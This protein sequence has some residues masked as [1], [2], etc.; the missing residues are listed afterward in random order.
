MT[1]QSD[2]HGLDLFNDNASALRGFPNAM[3]GYD[4]KAVDDYVREIEQHLMLARHQLREVKQELTAANLRVD[5]TDFSK[6]GSHTA[7]LLRI[8]EAQ[9]A[10]LVQKASDRADALLQDAKATAEQLRSDASVRT[11]QARRDGLESLRVLREDLDRQTASELGTARKEAEGFLGAARQEKDQILANARREADSLVEQAKLEGRRL[12]QAA[13][14][15]AADTRA[16]AAAE[17]RSVLDTLASEHEEHRKKLAG[18]A[19]EAEQ[20]A[21]QLRGTLDQA[22]EELQQRRQNT[23]AEAEKIKQD[24]VL[25]AA[26]ILD[27]ARAEADELAQETE[28]KLLKRRET[29]KRESGRLRARKEALIAQLGSLSTLASVTAGE[30]PDDFEVTGPIPQEILDEPQIDEDAAEQAEVDTETTGAQQAVRDG[31]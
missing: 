8:A 18:L 23:Y 24:A 9:A 16:A 22:A 28:S 25:E 15:E 6:L 21:G 29:L 19:S 5:D 4:K 30:F 26:S 1:E 12:V 11:E 14:Q 10:E 31:E 13:Q 20:R 17:Q 3:L 27:K 2:Q 7:N